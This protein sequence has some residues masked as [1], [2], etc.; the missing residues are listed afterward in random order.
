ME[1][2]STEIEELGKVSLRDL[3]DGVA[4]IVSPRAV[5]DTIK[6]FFIDFVGV[7]LEKRSYTLIRA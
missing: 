4:Q 5:V 2:V 3:M 6:N 1:L 7:G